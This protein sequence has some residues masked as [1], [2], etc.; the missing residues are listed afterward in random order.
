MKLN[1]I[2]QKFD[3]GNSSLI[4]GLPYVLE[5]IRTKERQIVTLSSCEDNHLVFSMWEKGGNSSGGPTKT[6]VLSP[7][8]V[9]NRYIPDITNTIKMYFEDD[10][11][12]TKITNEFKKSMTYIS[13]L[14]QKKE[15]KSKTNIAINT[16]SN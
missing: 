13:N 4:E 11:E 14:C 12:I 1:V 16:K 8:D 5:D 6:I 9:V 15:I 7:S 10:N 3:T 2:V